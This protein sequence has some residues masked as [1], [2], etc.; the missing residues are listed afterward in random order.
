MKKVLLMGRSGS[1]KSSMRSIVFSNY[2][3]KDTRR[4]GAT[5]DVEHSHVRFLG[6]LVLNLWDCGGQ[7]AFMENYLQ[8][9]RDHIFKHVEV[10]I[11]VFDVESR[12]F[13]RDMHT[14]ESCLD[15]VRANSPTAKVFCLIH[16]MDLVQEEMRDDVYLERSSYL[17]Q[18]SSGLKITCIATSIWDETLYKAWSSIVYTLIP[19]IP[20]LEKHLQVFAE[21]A[22][23]EEVVLFER[24]TF[25]VIS[26]ATRD[27]AGAIVQADPQR[28]EKISNIV[29]QFKLSCSRMSSQ[30]TSFQ[31]RSAQFSAFIAQY[32]GDTYIL[33]VMAG[34]AESATTLMNIDIA[35]RQFQKVLA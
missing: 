21:C 12:E 14:Y 28:F 26:H 34:D 24:T 35:R 4:L 17:E 18:R 6:N 16:K 7:E 1:G 31:M 2:V 19:N 11:Y 27:S 13:E 3:A 9:Q 8:S 25:L 29:K 5:I 33:V 10:L 32:T 15:A 23:A 30:F 20:T 22:D